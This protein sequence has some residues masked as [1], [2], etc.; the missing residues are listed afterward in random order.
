[1]IFL[2][3][4]I[5]VKHLLILYFSFFFRLIIFIS[6]M[7]RSFIRSFIG[8]LHYHLRLIWLCYAENASSSKNSKF[9]DKMC[10]SGNEYKTLY[11]VAVIFI[12]DYYLYWVWWWCCYIFC[13]YCVYMMMPLYFSFHRISLLLLFSLS[14]SIQ[15]NFV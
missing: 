2:L 4:N 3:N 15:P 1:M 7:C 6:L 11:C 10:T 13:C 9:T 8:V 12:F 14:R 5:R